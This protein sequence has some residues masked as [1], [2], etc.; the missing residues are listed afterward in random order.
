M[1]ESFR[2]RLKNKGIVIFDGAM[3][4]MLYNRGIFINASFD[5]CNI[6]RPDLV[7]EIHREY[8]RAGAEAIQTNTF[9]A[10]RMKLAAHG[11]AEQVR[12]INQAGVR[13]AREAS[14]GAALV[15]GSVGPLGQRIRPLGVL[16]RDEAKAAF[17]EQ[18]AALVEA[19]ADG[20][21]FET[22]AD[23]DELGIA[24]SAARDL[25]DL[26]IIAQFVITSDLVTPHG[27]PARDFAAYLAGR[28][29]PDVIGLNCGVGPVDILEA[30][31][32]ILPVLAGR[33][34]SAQPNAGFPR[35]V[36][37]R[38]ISLASPEY[39]TEY[40]KRFVELGV[41]IVGGCC[42]TTPDHI[43]ELARTLKG[44]D[45][46]RKRVR[47]ELPQ[48]AK[49]SVHPVPVDEKS[50]LAWK[51]RKGEWVTSVELTPP[52]GCSLE[53]TVTSAL[54]LQ[55]HGVDAV[56]I[57]DGP[58]ASSRLSPMVMAMELERKSKIETILHYC[59]R[60]RNL[61][62]MQA[63]LLGA[64]AAGLRNLLIITGDPPKVGSYP[65]A[66]G[67]FDVDSIGLVR[68]VRRL[69]HGLDLGGYA[70][71]PPTS[72]HIGVGVNP[73]AVDLDREMRRFEEKV[74][75]GAEFAI[76][77]PIFDVDALERF[78]R[79]IEGC[80]IPIL[81]GLW[82]LASFRNAEFLH[83]EVPG[84]VIPEEFRE[85]MRRCGTKEEAQREGAEIA[86]SIRDRIRS[87]VQGIQVSA[88]M[89]MI[90][91]ALEVIVD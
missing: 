63:D 25:S 45:F 81:A 10:N 38:Y 83:N 44:I 75:A 3:G 57:P 24:L 29:E 35:R 46:S 22:F 76:T 49:I 77:Q 37:G 31:E 8:V 54:R 40:G 27:V 34:V 66:T 23:P 79:R 74:E 60:D 69:N 30:L 6:H 21:I 89:E 85:R 72:L 78:L 11:L 4:T 67:V 58:R 68:L 36:E 17:Q 42:G 52:R 9:S 84:V 59:C 50:R 2:D 64:Q 1:T 39:F 18:V 19:G 88:P 55:R 86:R 70:V 90:R 65:D 47:V 13:L 5:A 14:S 80:R 15:F 28:S 33:P 20:L 62:S 91:L 87:E 41:S 16:P 51:L 71:D 61:I 32:Q 43:R 26:P 48:E 53:K 12:E 7:K 82:P 73:M 56:N